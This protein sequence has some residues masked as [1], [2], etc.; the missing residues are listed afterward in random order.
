MTDLSWTAAQ[1]PVPARVHAGSTTRLNGRSAPPYDSFNLADHVGDDPGAVAAN[2]RRL[3]Q[4]LQLPSEPAWLQQVHGNR[5]VH[6][7]STERPPADAGWTQTAGVVCAVLTADCLPLLL[8]DHRGTCIAAVH[9]GWR[10]LAAGVI[11]AAVARMPVPA[12]ELTAWLGPCIGPS[13]FEVGKDVYTACKKAL[14]DAGSAFRPGRRG[15]WWADLPALASL[16]LKQLN[17][18]ACYPS[19]LCTHGDP[20]RFYSHR[21]DGRTGRMASLIWIDA[22]S[23]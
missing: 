8:C 7:D 11:Q 14:P 5:V 20:Q 23:A 3:R 9:V 6:A 2:R 17:V 22:V 1:W 16:V 13:A 19:G 12:E 10:G 21:R 18:T 15:H 4:V